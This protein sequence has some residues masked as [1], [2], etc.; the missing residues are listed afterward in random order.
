MPEDLANLFIQTERDQFDSLSRVLSVL[1]SGLD[2]TPNLAAFCAS[3]IHFLVAKE[4][5][6]PFQVANLQ[7]I[8]RL[9]MVFLSET[10]RLILAQFGLFQ[11]FSMLRLD[12][13]RDEME[14]WMRSPFTDARPR[15]E[16]SEGG[17]EVP[18]AEI[19][20]P[21]LSLEQRDR[22]AEYAINDLLEL[23]RSDVI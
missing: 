1:S 16:K 23:Y 14:V 6:Y 17:I 8:Q 9:G 7:I 22:R 21:Y 19:F 4:F 11:F 18:D 2:G 5:H 3:L 13:Y 20:E 12:S 15:E 10:Q